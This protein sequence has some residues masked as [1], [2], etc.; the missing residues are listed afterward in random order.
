M[1]R[2]V[3]PIRS[4]LAMIVL[5]GTTAGAFAQNTDF[6]EKKIRPVLA[7]K[8]Y[9]CHGTEKQFGSL[10]LD[11]RDRILRSDDRYEEFREQ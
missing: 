9:G 1:L 11:S 8:C 4:A 6:F 3:A 10:R 2:A 5:A 7:T